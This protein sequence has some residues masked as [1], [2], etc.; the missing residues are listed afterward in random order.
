MLPNIRRIHDLSLI[1]VSGSPSICIETRRWRCICHSRIRITKPRRSAITIKPRYLLSPYTLCRP[2][3]RN[4]SFL[5]SGAVHVEQG[6]PISLPREISRRHEGRSGR[7]LRRLCLGRWRY[8]RA[9]R[10]VSIERFCL[11]KSRTGVFSVRACRNCNDQKRDRR[12]YDD[13]FCA[14]RR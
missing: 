9:H 6:Q 3:A 10:C 12:K 11:T 13:S 4:L 2:F 5:V 1:H 8:K 7:Q 14:R